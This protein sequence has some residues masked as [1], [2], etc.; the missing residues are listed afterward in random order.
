M[1]I[2]YVTVV[3]G[4]SILLAVVI[5]LVRFR[6]II[7]AYQ[8]FFFFVWV[9][10]C[11]HLLSVILI[12]VFRNNQI[13]G[14]IYVLIEA[15]ILLWLFSSW[16]LFHKKK[17]VLYTIL[18]ILINVWIFDNLIW[19]GLNTVNSL[20]RTVYSFT[21]TFLSINQINRIMAEERSNILRNSQFLI[22][23]AFI[24]Y[25]TY[26]ATIE[27]FYLIGLQASN[28]FYNN[29]FLIFIFVNLFANLIYAIAALWIPTKQKFILRS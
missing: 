10:C 6:K 16:G 7:P 26:K 1:S 22:C 4:F 19:H 21:L 18:V 25:Y 15:L 3:L 23:I 14:N 17:L 20:F 2:Y 8:P 29:L 5:G 24:I 27:V 13:N 28:N 11:N 9:N 12:E